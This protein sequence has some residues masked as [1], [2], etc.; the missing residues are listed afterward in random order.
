M[1]PWSA[2]GGDTVYDWKLP[3]W[4][5]R[6]PV[7]VARE[8]V[9]AAEEAGVEIFASLRDALAMEDKFAKILEA[10]KMLDTDLLDLPV[11]WHF[12]LN[13]WCSHF[14]LA[15]RSQ[16]HPAA[17]PTDVLSRLPPE[18]LLVIFAL[19]NTKQPVS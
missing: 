14:D 2:R 3:R 1:S 10:G 9:G 8:L 5:E 18:L 12:F 15:V 7:D 17:I 11:R 13:S 19:A 4:T 6:F 16:V